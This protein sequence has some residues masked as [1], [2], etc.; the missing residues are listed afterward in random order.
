[1]SEEEAKNQ[2]MEK[3]VRIYNKVCLDFLNKELEGSGLGFVELCKKD[4]EC[5]KTS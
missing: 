3:L 5:L 1:M 2:E 4:D